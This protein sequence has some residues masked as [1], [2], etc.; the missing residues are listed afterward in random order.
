MSNSSGTLSIAL[1]AN[2]SNLVSGLNS[3]Q[4]TIGRFTR[5]AESRFIKLKSVMNGVADKVFNKFTALGGSFLGGQAIND[6]AKFESSLA[7]LGIQAGKTPAEMAKVRAEIFKMGK[8]RGISKEDALAGITAMVDRTGDLEGAV[9]TFDT[10]TLASQASGASMESLG[11]LSTNL[12]SKMGLGPDKMNDALATLLEQGK[13]GEFQ[14]KSLADQG[15]RLFSA[16]SSFDMTGM[17]G[18]K[19]LG[20]VMQIIQAGTGGTGETATTAFE[21]LTRDLVA[22]KSLLK[23]KLGIDIIDPVASKKAGRE[24]FR[25]LPTI[26]QEIV[27]KSKG[28]KSVLQEAGFGDESMRALNGLSANYKLLGAEA[29]DAQNNLKKFLEVQGDVN[30]LNKDAS[31]YAQTFESKMA[32]LKATWD[33]MANNT[34]AKPGGIMDH[35]GDAMKWAS[36]HADV[37]N[38]ALKV[39]LGLMA[40]L[41]VLKAG[42]MVAEGIGTIRDTFGGGRG[43]GGLGGGL[44]GM[45]GATPVFVTNMGSGGMGGGG[46]PGGGMGGGGSVGNAGRTFGGT[47]TRAS[48]QMSI[49]FG[50]NMPT[51]ARM[52]QGIS[53]MGSGAFSFAGRMAGPLMSGAGRLVGGLG[54]LLAGA[55][56]LIGVFGA[57]A[58]TGTQLY[59]LYGALTELGQVNKDAEKMKA[60][61]NQSYTDSMNKQYGNAGWA[62]SQVQKSV[63]LQKQAQL[64]TDPKRKAQLEL[65]RMNVRKSL[66]D[67]RI[68]QVKRRLD[69]GNLSDADKKT[70]QQALN[71][72]MKTQEM[73]LKQIAEKEKQINIQLNVGP[74]GQVTS[75][76]RGGKVNLNKGGTPR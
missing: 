64:E 11:I 42:S 41:A 62:E 7:R 56:P 28:Q 31:D 57:L 13:A 37:M 50:R 54:G 15:E 32:R 67:A 61:I 18:V 53:R 39:T 47:M 63:D 76:A 35:I 65:E 30:N 66:G 9:K 20:A 25:D 2:N 27:K 73:W 5:T 74:N 1:R 33:E 29:F 38:T 58:F 75:D 23:K 6:I 60:Q 46:M 71:D 51:F 70:Q 34:L 26:M 12:G 17:K 45:N 72:A 59:Q 40:G 48:R 68:N 52:G 36:E 3:A 22:K 8:M 16:G 49:W 24:V 14:L 43:R 55:G 69:S 21:A 4:N 10:L 44:G 19:D